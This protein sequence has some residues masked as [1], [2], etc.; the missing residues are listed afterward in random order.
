M[1]TANINYIKSVDFTLW[2]YISWLETGQSTNH[3]Q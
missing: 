2:K 3:A 1:R